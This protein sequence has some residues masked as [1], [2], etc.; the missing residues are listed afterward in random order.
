[1]A[2]NDRAEADILNAVGAA[3][4]EI[5]RRDFVKT[6]AVTAGAVVVGASL[7]KSTIAKADDAPALTNLAASPPA[8]FTP[9]SAP[10]RV[11]KVTKA[12]S[13]QANGVYPKPDDAKEMLTR[14]M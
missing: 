3:K 9:Y 12:G 5:G 6:S 1:M 2:T 14:V 4:K 11:V 8:G 7:L 13:L 10:G